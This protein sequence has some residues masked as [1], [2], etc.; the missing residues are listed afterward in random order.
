LPLHR[1]HISVAAAAT[2]SAGGSGQSLI[3]GSRRRPTNKGYSATREQAMADFKAR[4]L[5]W[6][7]FK[8]HCGR[9]FRNIDWLKPKDSMSCDSCAAT[10]TLQDFKANET[11]DAA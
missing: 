8:P 5:S 4:W 3:G 10:I 11:R 1:A 7:Q 9:Q 6:G 2:T